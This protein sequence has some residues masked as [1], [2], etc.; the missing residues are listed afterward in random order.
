MD[1]NKKLSVFHIGTVYEI[2][3]NRHMLRNI[4]SPLKNKRI[5]HHEIQKSYEVIFKELLIALNIAK[6]L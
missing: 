5:I 3:N 6:F 1:R 2:H 4:E